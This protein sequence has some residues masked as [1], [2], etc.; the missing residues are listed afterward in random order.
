MGDCI[1]NTHD[2]W[3]RTYTFDFVIVA[4]GTGL[5]LRF[6]YVL[7]GV[8]DPRVIAIL[9][10]ASMCE[11]LRCLS[12]ARR[13]GVRPHF[14]C[15][16]RFSDLLAA[17]ALAVAPWPLT[18]PFKAASV[19]WSLCSLTSLATGIRPLVAL[20]VLFFSFRRLHAVSAIFAPLR[21]ERS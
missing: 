9:M 12:R 8:A 18:L 21:S 16:D 19:F 5:T 13:T 3:L 2:S 7:F 1:T 6:W 10:T 17:I 20:V 14:V 15:A 11:G 4:L